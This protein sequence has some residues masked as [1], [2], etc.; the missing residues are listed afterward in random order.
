MISPN[1]R[2]LP[3]PPSG[4][5]G[6]PWTEES[7][8]PQDNLSSE[9]HWPKLSIVTVT[10]NAAQFLEET[11]RSV[12][13]QGYPDLEYI[14]V[15]GGSTDGTVDII[16]KYQEWIARWISEPDRGQSHAINKGWAMATGEW[17]G[18][19]NADDIYLPGVL[20]S[21]SAALV[22]APEVDLV[23]G[24]VL[25]VNVDGKP[26]DVITYSEFSLHTMVM[27]GG[28]I[29]TPSVFWRSSLNSRA[30]ALYESHHYAM[31]NDFWLR[32][33]PLARCRYLPGAMS[34]F[35]RHEGSK[36]EKAELALIEENFAIFRQRLQEAPYANLLSEQEA[37]VVLGGFVWQMAVLLLRSG[38]RDEA[39]QRFREAIETY[40]IMETPEAAAL[41]T[42]KKTL[43]N[44]VLER[45]EITDI[46]EALPIDEDARRR[47]SQLVWDH[48]WQVQFYGSFQR[49]DGRTV[50]KSALPLLKSD[51]RR[52]RQ[53]GF[54]S[55]CMRSITSRS[56]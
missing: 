30:G 51:P 8:M 46:L 48:Y 26:R 11:I 18:W 39:I 5:S 43:E 50:L 40:H 47:F 52:A 29:H 12:L 19:L 24:D 35:R 28:L 38:R 41:R 23:Y 54:L 55:I 2:L 56:I 3:A 37:N 10:Y 7:P 42:V 4:K 45:N 49:R 14:I 34:T 22:G 33:A 25:Y 13:L 17:L 6:W 15:D 16:R 27:R 44:H 20:N 53:R 9:S 21:V 36:T 32:V 31:D 1:L